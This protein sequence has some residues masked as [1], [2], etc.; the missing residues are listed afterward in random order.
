VVPDLA[1]RLQGFAVRVAV[2]A[3]SVVDL[4][5][6]P[7]RATS[8]QELDAAVRERADTGPLAGILEY[9]VVPLVSS[10]VIGSAYSSMFDA[11]LTTVVV[12]TEAKIVA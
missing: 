1:G 9:S 12:G 10:D 8:V 6:E 3:A 4:T 7:E 5:V 2:P 11:G